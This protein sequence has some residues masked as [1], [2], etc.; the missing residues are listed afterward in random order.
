VDPSVGDAA[1]AP[2]DQ[3]LCGWIAGLAPPMG[4]ALLDWEGEAGPGRLKSKGAVLIGARVKRG[5]IPLSAR[6]V[7]KGS[8]MLGAIEGVLR[9]DG[10]SGEVLGRWL[11][12]KPLLSNFSICTSTS[13]GTGVSCVSG[14]GLS[15][16]YS[17]APSCGDWGTCRPGMYSLE[18]PEVDPGPSCWP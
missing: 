10:N 9:P 12:P 1:P 17:P 11:K 5:F 8:G 7:G 18:Y 4:E 3:V 14:S 15:Y 6:S 2:G 16:E 13:S